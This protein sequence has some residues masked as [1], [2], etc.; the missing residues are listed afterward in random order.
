V[1]IVAPSLDILGGQAIQ[2]DR[3]LQAWADDPQIRAWLVP[4]NPRPPGPLRRL[5]SVKYL[6]TIL[7]QLTY[8]PLLLRELRRAD[9]VHIFSASYWSFLLAPLPAAVVARMLGKPI[10]M[11][12]RS[13][14]APDHLRRSAL[15]RAVLRAVDRNVV[16]SK[17][18]QGVFAG[19]GID[20]LI[21]PNIVDLDRF[22]FRARKPLRPHLLSTRNF[23]PLYNVRCTLAAFAAI[24]AR[25]PDARLTLVGAGSDEAALRR[26]A[27]ALELRHVRFAGAVPPDEIWRYYADA[28]IYIQTPDI[29]NAPSSV[30]EAFASGCAVVSTDAGGVPALVSDGVDGLLVP[31]GDHQRAALQVGRLLED[32]GLAERLTTRARQNCDA[33]IWSSVRNRWESLYHDVAMTSD[34]LHAAARS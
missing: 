25:Y 20:A 17:F 23:E 28:D 6:R 21:I 5:G 2:A 9:V 27:A 31:C 3:L 8:W 19:F 22:V 26:M 34:A 16:P 11:N 7:T 1:A 29:D 33:Y 13:G 32:P 24:Q 12:Y 4:V 10:V 14:E 18:L 15:S 30:I